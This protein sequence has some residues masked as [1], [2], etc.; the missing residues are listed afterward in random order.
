MKTIPRPV[1]ACL[2]VAVLA[3]AGCAASSGGGQPD[4]AHGLQIVASTDVYGDI[5]QA[6][7]GDNAEVTSL[8]T[9]PAQ[10]PHSFEASA[11]DQLAVLKADLV[12]ENGGGYDPFIDTLIEASDNTDAVVLN[13]VD[14]S[15]LEAGESDGFNEHVWYSFPAVGLVAK[16]IAG[17]LS[18]LDPAHKDAY[19]TNYEAFAGKV[20]GLEHQASE[21][22]TEF[23]A[24]G[25][26]I[27]EPVPL[28]LLAAAGLVNKTPPEFSE[29]VEEG[30]DLSPRVL[31]ETLDL[32]A[33]G[34]VS[35]LAY[36]NQTTSAETEQV[37]AAAEAAG[38]AVVNFTETLPDGQDYVSWMTVNLDAVSGALG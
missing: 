18:K 6:V 4:A 5:A 19:Q 8:I 30:T 9:S 29:A 15:G 34:E 1:V 24:T 27:T 14:I 23:D 3:L 33:S 37:R 10:D 2:S 22:K 35:M 7:A 17:E 11:Q 32:F 36:N 38:V 12:I 31:K 28:Y 21:L 16:H 20:R 25:V 13:A 26:A